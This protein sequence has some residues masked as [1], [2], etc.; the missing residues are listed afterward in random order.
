MGFTDVTESAGV[1]YQQHALATP[2]DCV[3]VQ[4]CDL[5][6]MSGGAAVADVDGDGDPDLFVT[7]LDAPDILFENQGNGQFVDATAGSGLE[8]FDLQSNGAAFGDV[9]ND[10]DPDLFVVVLAAPNDPVNGRNFLFINDGDGHFTEE[11]VARGADLSTDLPRALWSV[12]FGDYD[13]DG[14]LDVHLTEWSG[15][16]YAWSVAAEPRPRR[17]GA[18]RG[19]DGGGG[20]RFARDSRVRVDVRRSRR[21][22]MAGPRGRR[23]LR[24]EPAL[25]G[26]TATGPFVMGH[27]RRGSAPTRTAW[28]RRSG[29]STSTATSIGS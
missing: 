19:R 12:N 29:T 25:L 27:S 20:T 8:G 17:S 11:A 9:D 28:A 7:R 21:R 15:A 3:F 18:V 22:R 26:T 24:H 23:G 6:R 10:G 16:G 13:R 14:W 4:I 1:V 2:P 5:D